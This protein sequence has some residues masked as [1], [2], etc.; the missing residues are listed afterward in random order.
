MRTSQFGGGSSH[1]S[2]LSGL[3]VEDTVGRQVLALPEASQSL[4]SGLL[5]A[6][7]PQMLEPDCLGSNPSSVSLLAVRAVILQ[8]MGGETRQLVMCDSDL[9]VVEK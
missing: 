8:S 3:S 7:E 9:P 4:S 2:L 6:P 5:G 1:T